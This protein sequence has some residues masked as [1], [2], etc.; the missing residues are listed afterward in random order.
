MVCAAA[1]STTLLMIGPACGR[2]ET[3]PKTEA[4]PREV[5]A[6]D[7][8]AAP[9]GGGQAAVPTAP[10][11]GPEH[12]V[13]SMIDNR[14]A[15]HALVEGYPVVV[16][17]SAGFPK[18]LRFSRT[19]LG[20]DIRQKRDGKAV[21]VMGGSAGKVDVPVTAAQLGSIKK[22]TFRVFNE[23]ARRM[24]VRI[25]GDQKRELPAELPAGWATVSVDVPDGLLRAGEN[26][27]VVFAS[28]GAPMTVEWMQVG[29]TVRGDDAPKRF[30]PAAGAMVLP[31]NDG[32]AFFAYVPEN[33]RVVGDLATAGCE[34]RVTAT[35]ESGKT[36]EGSLVGRG[37]AVE[38]GALA[39]QAVR[40][41]LAGAKCP[42]AHLT[43][44]GIA[45]PGAAPSA[46]PAQA[47]APKYVVFWVMDS[48]RADR[49]STFVP[50][51]RPEVPTFDELAKTSAVFLQ[52]YVQ[53]N[54]SRVSHASMWS[55]LYPV[56]HAML[57]AKDK[58]ATKW[59]TIDEVANKAG[60]YTSGVSA[61]GYVAIKWGFGEKWNAYA[62]HI[63]ES[64][65]LKGEDILTAGLKTVE[66]KTEPWFLYVG[67]IDTHVSWRAKEPWMSKYAKAYSG[68][69]QSTFSGQDA[70]NAATGK[71]KL[72]DAD[73]EHVRA[74]YD[75]NVSY[76]DKLLGD[77]LTKLT[78]WGI[79]DQTM[80]IITA[81]HGD[82]QWE[83]G[84]VG[85]GAS[86][87]DSLVHVPLLVHYPPLVPAGKYMEGA[88]VVDIVPTVAE[89]LGVAADKE[90]QGESLI[91]I[92]QGPRGGYPRLSMASMYEG[93]HAGRLAHWKVFGSG[94]KEDIYNL[95]KDPGET[96]DLEGKAPIGGRMVNDALWMLRAYNAEWNKALWGNAANTTDKF[97][98]ALGE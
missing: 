10:S 19:K 44:A 34:V 86:L 95:A 62:N 65:G 18:Y 35:G 78:E 30:D 52:S 89:A 84:R 22:I 48:L 73:K 94:G 59:T 79:R 74:I 81:D 9:Q 67:T 5:A 12:M 80:I 69:F 93:S 77:L 2:G 60:L 54:E 1:L 17:G 92:A 38:L 98:A 7:K 21:A 24:G 66:G 20:W 4:P 83:V 33:G 42:S 70:A 96:T 31:E 64:K 25:N 50:G 47:P 15:A 26:E 71:L 82:E 16:H 53:G 75:S 76:Q 72:S 14:L 11:R 88:E 58:L 61:N 28:K 63:H 56:K 68:K 37:S 97:A 43:G 32:V 90:W 87:R 3:S 46:K 91:G 23:G 29:G 39:G 55:S 45:V 6:V 27:I 51:A 49:I 36:A 57:G 40:I 41:E 85:H 13:Y 8:G